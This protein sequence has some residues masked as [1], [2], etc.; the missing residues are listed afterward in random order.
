MSRTT[1]R[2]SLNASLRRILEED[3]RVLVLG[4]DIADPYGGAFKVTRSLSTDFPDRVRVTPVSE[5]G[6]VGLATGLALRGV[7]AVA[8]V[9]FGDFIT[10]A[11]DQLINHAAKFRGMYNGQAEVPLV[12]RTPMGGGRGYGPTHSQSLEKH[13]LGV[14]GLKVVS[15][16]HYHDPGALLRT[17]LYDPDPVLF[18]EHKLLYPLD[19]EPAEVSPEAYPVAVVRNLAS[20][21]ADV[22]VLTYGGMARWLPLVFQRQ[23]TAG[24]RSVACL[25]SRIDRFDP[26]PWVL[27]LGVRRAVLVEEGTAGFGWTAEI[28]ARLHEADLGCRVRRVTAAP[29]IIPAAKA[30]EEAMLPSARAIEEACLKLL[31]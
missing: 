17:A 29:T 8:E 14:P 5:A 4:E 18:I 11:S 2:T 12:V 24:I 13:Y 15:P 7:P 25:P 16:S 20:E 31:A 21:E 26:V 30:S 10:L 6:I 1:Y 22:L 27:A 23:A 3:P 28:A 9:M 19:L